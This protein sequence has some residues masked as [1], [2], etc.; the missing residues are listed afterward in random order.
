MTAHQPIAQAAEAPPEAQAMVRALEAALAASERLGDGHAALGEC[1]CLMLGEIGAGAPRYEA[2][3]NVRE[4]ARWWADTATPD[5]LEIYTAA[6]LRRIERVRFAEA[7]RKRLLVTLWES[8]DEAGRAAFLAKVVPAAIAQRE[9][10]VFETIKATVRPSDYDLGRAEGR[11]AFDRALR[12][13][14][15]RHCG[16]DKQFARHVG[17]MI[18]EWRRALL[19]RKPP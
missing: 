2:L 3:G 4:D 12:R 16:A 7:A 14:V 15:S 8:M 1:L 17:D 6:A 13:E 10:N 9:G 19:G 18:A 11:L 5:E